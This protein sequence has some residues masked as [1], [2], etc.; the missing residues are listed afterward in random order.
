MDNR[1]TTDYMQERIDSL[2]RELDDT[3]D[4]LHRTRTEL[5][6][7]R[8]RM[9]DLVRL[10]ETTGLPNNRAFVERL[11]EEVRRA[12]RFDLPLSI[13]LADIDQFDDYSENRSKSEFEAMLGKL[14]R[15]IQKDTRS[16][17][18]LVR[19]NEHQF[20]LLLPGTAQAGAM[21]LAERLCMR[22]EMQQWNIG[23]VTLSCGVTTLSNSAEMEQ[24][25]AA[26]DAEESAYTTL[27]DQKRNVINEKLVIAQAYKAMRHSTLTGRN[28]VV[29]ALNSALKPIVPW[30][31]VPAI[32]IID[33]AGE[34]A[35]VSLDIE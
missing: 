31:D 10:D 33:A 17:D 7:S 29:H 32:R 23:E 5:N 30:D 18:Y 15:L 12:A 6:A 13:L 9:R 19:Y 2:I 20:G 14:V 21:L 24:E 25:S 28:R 8:L 26:P 16:I 27:S 4:E 34:L 1:S 35:L 22:I 3:R 11:S